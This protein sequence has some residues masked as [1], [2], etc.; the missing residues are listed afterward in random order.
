MTVDRDVH[1]A[2][3]EALKLARFMW[4]HRNLWFADLDPMKV[5]VEKAEAQ[6]GLTVCG[7]PADST[8]SGSSGDSNAILKGLLE[9][10]YSKRALIFIVDAPSVRALENRS[11]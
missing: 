3:E 5:I 7:D 11:M 8:A 4:D 1:R 9:N 6:D 2:E 10:E